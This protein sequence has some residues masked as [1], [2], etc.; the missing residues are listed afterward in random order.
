MEF[1]IIQFVANSLSLITILSCLF[2]KV[3]QIM[4]IRE[5]RSAKGLYAQAMLLE[6]SG[7]TIMILYNYTNNYNVLTYLEYPI[8]IAQLY[9][10]IYYVL[11]Y[12]NLM[13]LPIVPLA[14]AIYFATVFGFV[15]GIIPKE[16]LEYMVPL[17]T[18]LSGF[19]KVTYIIGIVKSGNAEAV[20]LTT[21]TI[22]LLTNLS[23]LFTV[24]V[25][26]AD[27][28][29]LINFMVSSLLSFGVLSTAFY[30][31]R[32]APPP[33]VTQRRRSKSYGRHHHSHAD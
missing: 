32:T 7:F 9:V 6:I 25:D 8:I 30:Y 16:V 12:N 18:P 17:N 21:W 5:K 26:S 27:T 3:P 31:K 13:N 2:L 24:Y 10:L 33:P 22:S 29:L 28:Y 14:T 19:A 11:K 1:D 15:L 23:R 4:Y 20:S